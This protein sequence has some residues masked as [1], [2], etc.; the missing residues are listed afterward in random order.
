MKNIRIIELIRNC[1][2]TWMMNQS[3]IQRLWGFFQGG[4]FLVLSK[5]RNGEMGVK[6]GE[7]GN[8]ITGSLNQYIQNPNS[9]NRGIGNRTKSWDSTRKDAQKQLEWDTH[10]KKE[11]RVIFPQAVSQDWDGWPKQP[12]KKGDDDHHNNHHHNHQISS[13]KKTL[14]RITFGHDPPRNCPWDKGLWQ[15]FLSQTWKAVLSETRYV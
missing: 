1:E 15:H 8:R 12:A 9:P 5:R 13:F 2:A 14:A 3:S 6:M 11:I 10:R 7:W 4:N